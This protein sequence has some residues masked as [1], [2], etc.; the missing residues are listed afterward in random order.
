[1]R[2]L[3]RPAHVQLG[4]LVQEFDMNEFKCE[5]DAELLQGTGYA[6]D[7][8]GNSFALAAAL[9]TNPDCKQLV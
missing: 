6:L 5:Q 2:A 8:L 3:L 4:M 7:L 9:S 1:M